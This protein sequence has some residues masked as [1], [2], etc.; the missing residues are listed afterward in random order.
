VRTALRY[1]LSTDDGCL[2]L[3]GGE[4]CVPISSA[5]RRQFNFSMDTDMPPNISA[6]ISVGY[7]LTEDAHL[8]RKFAQLVV[9]AAVTVNFQAGTP[10]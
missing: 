9:T 10:R 4:A 1:A 8:N 5:S 6:G 3:A 2:T 7:I